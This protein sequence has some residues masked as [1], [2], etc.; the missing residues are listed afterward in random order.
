MIT[1]NVRGSYWYLYCYLAYLLLIPLL[2]GIANYMDE[3]LLVYIVILSAFVDLIVLAPIWIG[4]NISIFYNYIY[5]V[6]AYAFLFPLCGYGAY[7]YLQKRSLCLLQIGIFLLI[8]LMTDIFLSYL[9]HSEYMKTG[10]WENGY[11]WRLTSL[12]VVPVFMIIYNLVKHIKIQN[13]YRYIIA[14]ISDSCFGIYLCENIL[15]KYTIKV[16]YW[17]YEWTGYRLC[18]CF[19][20]LV[21]TI[22]VGTVVFSLLK[23]C[24]PAISKIL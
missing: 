9:I 11:T 1:G 18:S 19:A 13:K 17:L 14:C 5:I 24:F 20:Y 15:E 12:M 7:K 6:N 10:I 2:E 23:K 3:K 16:Y 21:V 4:D 8:F 22:I